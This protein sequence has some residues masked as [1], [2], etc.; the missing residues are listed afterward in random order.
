MDQVERLAGLGQQEAGIVEGEE[1]ARDVVVAAALLWWL[2][3]S[4]KITV[5][6]AEQP[7]APAE[8]KP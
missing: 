1:H 7:V 4:L 3:R 8:R 6:T 2:Y 5:G